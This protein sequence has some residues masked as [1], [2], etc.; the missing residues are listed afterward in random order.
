MP[1]LHVSFGTGSDDLRGGSDN[2]N[3]IALLQDGT[4]IRFDNVNQSQRWD[5]N[6]TNRV[7]KELP[8][9]LNFGNITG[10]QLETTFRWGHRWRQLESQV[11]VGGRGS[12]LRALLIIRGERRPASPV[13]W[14]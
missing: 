14:R 8:E 2:V 13:Y 10:V 4:Q 1:E 7:T 12:R 5:N 9:G 11:F 6:S 3:L